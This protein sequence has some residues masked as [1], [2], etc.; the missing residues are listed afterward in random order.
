MFIDT[1][2]EITYTDS[3]KKSKKWKDKKGKKKEKRHYWLLYITIICEKTDYITNG[4]FSIK[5]RKQ[6]F[7]FF[8]F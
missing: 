3:T 1:D 7:P 6:F 5:D 4:M 2:T 8:A